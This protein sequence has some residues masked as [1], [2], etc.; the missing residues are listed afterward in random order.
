METLT[1]RQQEVLDFVTNYFEEKNYSPTYADISAHFGW[2]SNN[3]SLEHLRAIAKKGYLV[4]T[5][6]GYA[7]IKAA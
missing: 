5:P 3:A 7:P 6:R 1:E 2:T 4:K